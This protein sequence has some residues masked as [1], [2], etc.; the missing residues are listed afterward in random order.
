[1]SPEQTE[2]HCKALSHLAQRLGELGLPREAI[3]V[4]EALDYLSEVTRLI[5]SYN[6]ESLQTHYINLK[7]KDDAFQHIAE[8]VEPYLENY[9]EC[10]WVFD[11]VYR[12]ALEFQN[13]S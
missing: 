10:S 7:K 4:R 12:I 5:D 9:G 1:M 2:R 8:T 13:K 11:A 6:N 3:A